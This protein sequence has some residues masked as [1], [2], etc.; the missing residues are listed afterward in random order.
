[1]LDLWKDHNFWSDEP[2]A[3]VALIDDM[4]SRFPNTNFILFTSLENIDLESIKSTNIQ[5]VPWGGD[6]VNQADTYQSI[7]PVL[8]KNFNSK[9]TFISLNRNRRQHRVATLSYLF[10]KG[11]DKF[12]EITYLGQYLDVGIDNLLDYLPWRFNEHQT[13]IRAAM[14]DGYPKFYNNKSLATDNYEIYDEVND[15]V[16]NFNQS[17]SLKYENS[18]VEIVS[19][20]SFS[21]PSFM[22]TE[23]W[24]NSV[25]GCNFPILV[26]GCGTI[27]HL[28]EVGFDVFEDIVDHSYDT[29]ANPFDR[30]ATAI[31]NNHRL[32]T[33]TDYAKELWKSNQH[34]FEKNIDIAKNT[35][36]QWYKDRT[37]RQ[38]NQL[39]WIN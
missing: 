35:I 14:I 11:Y 30:I 31:D 39:T 16:K 23:K 7:E 33:D 12:G 24:M 6:I 20:S 25:Y 38:F 2:S 19:E 37:D 34:R 36:Y 13:D 21:A 8:D 26:S 5:F 27:A 32:L 29:I 17:L 10:G 28:R 1:M 22:I 15:N 9:K 4:A 3:G 18:F